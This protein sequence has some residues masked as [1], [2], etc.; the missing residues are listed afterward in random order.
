MQV[1]GDKRSIYCVGLT[2][3]DI[4]DSVDS[5]GMTAAEIAWSYNDDK[6]YRAILEGGCTFS[7]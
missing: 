5:L 7:L 6:T 4:W 1:R 2:S 3:I